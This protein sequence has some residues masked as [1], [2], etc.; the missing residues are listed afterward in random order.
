MSVYQGMAQ[1]QALKMQAEA[2][3]RQASAQQMQ[4][5]NRLRQVLSMNTADAAARGVL[6]G[7]SYSAAQQSILEGGMIGMGQMESDL[8]RKLALYSAARKNALMS[9]YGGAGVS[10]LQ[11][12]S[13][14]SGGRI[15]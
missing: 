10:G 5:Q 13:Y 1:E 14:M 8:Q 7:G 4:Y 15:F 6:G 9:G 2:E 3:K 12:G 11:L